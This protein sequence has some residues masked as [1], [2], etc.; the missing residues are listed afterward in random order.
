LNSSRIISRAINQL[1]NANGNVDQ[2]VT[3]SV[4][5][6]GELSEAEG[7]L[8]AMDIEF[9]SMSSMEKRGAQLK[10]NDYREELKQLQSTYTTSKMSAE[11]QALKGGP[12]SR[13]RLLNS[14][15]KLDNSTATLEKSRQILANTQQ[16]GDTVLTDLETQKETLMDA[17]NKVK[18]TKDFTSEARRVLRMMGNRAIIHKICVVLIIIGLAA[19]IIATGY[20]GVTKKH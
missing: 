20:Y 14:N 18:E 3:A 4:E 9:R 15:Q 16:I 13:T 17:R 5:I 2:I 7:F 10:L 8:R 12:S 6:E 1:E 11:A 19:A